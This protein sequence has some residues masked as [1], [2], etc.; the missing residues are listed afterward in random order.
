MTAKNFFKILLL[1]LGILPNILFAQE[2]YPQN[3]FDLP[4]QNYMGLSGIFAELRPNHFH[5]GIDFRTNGITGI[6]V[7]SVAK[8]YVSRI[9][10]SATG[11]GK[12]L[13][14]NHPNGYKSVYMHLEQFSEEIATFVEKYQYENRTFEF[15]I[16]VESSTLPVEKNQLIALS[17][18]SGSSG[19]PH[20]HFEIRK[21][22]ND[23]VINPLFF[24]FNFCD[25]ISPKINEIRIYPANKSTF[26]NN[27]NLSIPLTDKPVSQKISP[28]KKGSKSKK[29]APQ[30]TMKSFYKGDTLQVS[31]DVYFGISSTDNLCNSLGGRGIYSLEVLIDSVCVYSH[32]IKDFLFE[33]T[34]YVNAMIDYPLFQKT[35]KRFYLTKLPAYI[36]MPAIYKEVKNGGIYSFR[37]GEISQVLVKSSDFA[38]NQSVDTFYLQAV[39]PPAMAKTVSTKT[40][41]KNS[42]YFDK[43]NLFKQNNIEIQTEAFSLYESIDFKYNTTQKTSKQYLPLCHQIHFSNVPLHKAYTLK[44]SAKSIP[45]SLRE[46]AVIVFIEKGISVESTSLQGNYLVAKPKTFGLFS[47]A[48]DTTAPTIKP[49]FKQK[50]GEKLKNKNLSFTIRDNLSGINTYNCFLDSQWILAEYDKKSNLLTLQL[51][52]KESIKKEILTIEVSDFCEN[53]RILT[54]EINR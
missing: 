45:E 16:P 25:S 15:D 44:L 20:L 27:K 41:L 13:Y 38:G 4:F 48:I 34:R 3:Y 28:K 47:I 9:K 40:T 14:I 32:C 54:L 8:G 2:D 42:F 37:Q 52:E 24:G 31:G 36:A 12:T 35:G 49:L 1:S 30:K 39:P 18:N 19:G 26:I 7:Y 46:K 29:R 33:D 5:S 6:P 50:K 11:G 23:R 22:E 10:V 17:G 51:P 53:K 43:A 21:T